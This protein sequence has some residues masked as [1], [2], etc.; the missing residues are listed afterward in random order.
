[1][2]THIMVGTNDMDR[3]RGF[4][5]GALGAL[6][7]KNLMPPEA[8]R[9]AFRNETGAFVVG[10]PANGEPA[11]FGNGAMVSFKAPDDAAVDAF[12]AAGLAAGGTC[13]GAPGIRTGGGSPM[14][15]AYL[16]DPEGNKISA[17]ARPK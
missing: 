17:F 2:F 3:A 13:E 1:M 15:G 6:G 7:L 12:H 10:K 5:E 8:P 4:Y 11:T 9:L 16:R 14:Y